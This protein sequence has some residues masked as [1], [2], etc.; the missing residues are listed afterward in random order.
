MP[1]LVCEFLSV[2]S[3]IE[4]NNHEVSYVN[5][6]ILLKDIVRIKL[7]VNVILSETKN[8]NDDRDASVALSMT[9]IVLFGLI[10]NLNKHSFFIFSE[11]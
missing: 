7:K 11:S 3:I 9:S 4:N 10:Q 2:S 8:L 6:P 1:T 5:V